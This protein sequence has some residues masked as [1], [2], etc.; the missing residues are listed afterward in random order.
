M[1]DP[2][3]EGKHKAYIRVAMAYVISPIDVLPERRFGPPAY[4]DDVV[5]IVEAPEMLFNEVDRQIIVEHWSGKAALLETIGV[6]KKEM[7]T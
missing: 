3:I 6:R 7:S 2:R 1:L 5:V 4:L